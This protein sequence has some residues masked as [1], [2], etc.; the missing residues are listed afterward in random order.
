MGICVSVPMTSS[1]FFS[2]TLCSVHSFT[3]AF[4]SL[5]ACACV[6]VCGSLSLSLASQCER[7]ARF[8]LISCCL[9]SHSLTLSKRARAHSTLSLRRKLCC[10]RKKLCAILFVLLQHLLF[11]LLS[12]PPSCSLCLAL[13]TLWRFLCISFLYC[14][15]LSAVI[16]I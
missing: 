9:L 13:A 5:R 1:I 6:C 7:S 2:I 11:L 10:R 14:A 4:L 15:S 16:S 8:F 3:G 12:L